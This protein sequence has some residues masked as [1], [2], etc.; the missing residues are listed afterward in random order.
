M[1]PT[2]NMVKYPQLRKIYLIEPTFQIKKGEL[3]S[4][5]E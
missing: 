1:T 2:I 5:D 4:S 3:N